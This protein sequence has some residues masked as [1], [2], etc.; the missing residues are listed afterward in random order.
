[1]LLPQHR[2]VGHD[3]S[4]LWYQRFEDQPTQ[5]GFESLGSKSVV[6][7]RS[8][9]RKTGMNEH[10]RK[11]VVVEKQSKVQNW[12]NGSKLAL[13]LLNRCADALNLESVGNHKEPR[14]RYVPVGRIS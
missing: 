11:F 2:G 7:R 1:L 6:D 5:G 4:S 12:Q 13:G 9:R 8:R 14:S 3:F 10:K